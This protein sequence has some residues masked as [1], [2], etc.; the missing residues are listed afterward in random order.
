[1]NKLLSLA[2]AGVAFTAMSQPIYAK[3]H[4]EKAGGGARA[5]SGA[6]VQQRVV[7]QQ[8]S[9]AMQR[10]AQSTAKIERRAVQN[11]RPHVNSQTRVVTPNRTVT[12]TQPSVAFGGQTRA[13]RRER[14]VATDRTIARREWN[15]RNWDG[16][17][18]GNRGDFRY[19]RPPV[20]TYRNWDRD[21]I[22]DW[23]NHRWHWYGGSWAIVGALPNYVYYDEPIATTYAYSS[24]SIVADVQRELAREGYDA[25][26]IDGVLGGQTRSAIAAF[27]H[28]NGLAATGRID[29]ALLDELNLR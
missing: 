10:S 5:A 14:T 15:G 28:D 16:D 29:T 26:P 21:R 23:D 12:Q 3:P 20:T 19:R 25:G 9:R 11:V 2:V 18:N 6:H 1:M 27:Q 8:P 13:E 24:G 4:K 7:Q 22:H 17:R